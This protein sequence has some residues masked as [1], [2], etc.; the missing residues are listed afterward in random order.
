MRWLPQKQVACN[1]NL[2]RETHGRRCKHPYAVGSSLASGRGYRSENPSRHGTLARVAP[3]GEAPAPVSNHPATATSPRKTLAV[4]LVLCVI[5][6]STW[7][8]IKVGLGDLPPFTFAGMRFV[9][10]A[11][12]L[13]AGC[14]LGGVPIRPA[15]RGDWG[16]LAWTG[17]LSFFVNYGLLFWA[18]QHISSGLAAVLQATIPAFGMLFA[19]LILPAEPLTRA[20]TAGTLLG[21]A[22]VAT[23]FS[24]QFTAGGPLAFAGS[25]AVVTGAAAVAFAN[26][27]IKARGAD[28]P[29]AAAMAAWQMCFGLV[30]LLALG[31]WREGDPR[32]MHWSPVAVGCLLY[33][34]LVGSSLAFFLF[35]WLT[36]RIAVTTTMS[37]SLVTPV[38]AVAL[39]WLALGETLSWRTA[40]GAVGVLAGVLLVAAGRRKVEG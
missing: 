35:Y 21:L 25:A 9:V 22:G 4:W 12:V 11:A 30:P 26:V 6:G 8:A 16:F 29:P 34:A 18:E 28:V 31:L 32:R 5:W 1:G 33:L 39:G 20:G 10:A 38:I 17:L 23:I 7:L 15:G 13:F 37:I 14:A 2:P 40:L 24:H 36:R 3:A 19:H 27:R